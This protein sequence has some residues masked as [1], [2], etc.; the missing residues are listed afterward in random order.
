MG[1]TQ[2]ADSMYM[3]V[4]KFSGDVKK[5]Q[6]QTLPAFFRRVANLPYKK[7][8]TGFEIV[9]RPKWGFVLGRGN[10][11]DCKK[12]SQLLGAFLTLKKIPWRFVGSSNRPGGLFSKPRIHHVFVQGRFCDFQ[13]GQ[14]GWKN[15]DATYKHYRMFQPKKNVTRAII[16]ERANNAKF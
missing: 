8:P 15:L 16:F 14:C 13:T 3:M 11:I 2:T 9:A 6:N 7:D 12:K 10:G 1:K 4:E 5:Y